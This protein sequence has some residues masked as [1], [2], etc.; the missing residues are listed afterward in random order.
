VSQHVEALFCPV[1]KRDTTVDVCARCP[2]PMAPTTKVVMWN[3]SDLFRANGFVSAMGA[4][5]KARD[6]L[7]DG[8][9]PRAVT[10]AVSFLE[11]AMKTIHD[12]LGKPLP[13]DQAVTSLWK[14]TRSILVLDDVDAAGT[15]TA[16]ANALTGLVMHLGR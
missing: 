11:S 9:G 16:L 3:A 6:A 13:K 10:H 4:F 8:D 1:R 2:I 5:E 15:T 7:R 12:L 14:P